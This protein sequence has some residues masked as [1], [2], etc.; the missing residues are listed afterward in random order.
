[1]RDRNLD[2][3]LAV[4]IVGAFAGAAVNDLHSTVLLPL[5]LALMLVT[6]YVAVEALVG[7]TVTGLERTASTAAIVLGVPA[8]GGVLLYVDGV[9]LHR[10]GWVVLL[11]GVTLLAALVV[12]MRRQGEVDA[13]DTGGTPGPRAERRPLGHPAVL[14]A[15]AVVAAVAVWVSVG[16]A[17]AQRQPGFTQLSLTSQDGGAV[18]RVG[19]FEGH[20]ERYLLVL[21][22]RGSVLASYPVDLEPRDTWTL[23][24]APPGR[25]AL[26]ADL[27][28][29]SDRL[30][31]Y[32]SVH[33]AGAP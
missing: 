17:N 10:G 30:R 26:V 4:V 33:L 28:V 19:N 6:G 31:P 1:M 29:G 5:G 14:G 12:G 3:V 9:P 27:F 7:P 23:P 22:S 25:A 18:L 32:R 11:A 8:V 16:G 20:R 24:V 2:L 13:V 21:R 15:A